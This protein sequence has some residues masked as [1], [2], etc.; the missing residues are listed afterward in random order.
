MERFGCRKNYDHRGN[1]EEKV[2]SKKT[3]RINT[4]LI[5]KNQIFVTQKCVKPI[6]AWYE[7]KP[8]FKINWHM[9]L[10]VIHIWKYLWKFASCVLYS[11]NTLI[12]LGI[13][14]R[15]FMKHYFQ[16]LPTLKSNDELDLKNRCQETF[17]IL[18]YAPQMSLA[19]AVQVFVWCKQ[20]IYASVL[21]YHSAN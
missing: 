5:L 19:Y 6:W 15:L 14:L 1:V 21:Q 7:K 3:H 13:A 16:L 2:F 12:L 8:L 9:L 17:M 20:N 10:L 4:L 11:Y 18:P